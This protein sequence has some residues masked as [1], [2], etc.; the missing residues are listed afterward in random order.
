MSESK[1]PWEIIVKIIIFIIE[2]IHAGLSEKEAMST[3]SS[4]FNVPFGT[5]KEMWKNRNV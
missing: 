5:V 1:I 2:Q 4:K 3:A